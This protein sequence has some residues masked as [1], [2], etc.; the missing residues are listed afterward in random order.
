MRLKLVKA[1]AM[2]GFL[3]D[4]FVKRWYSNGLM[5]IPLL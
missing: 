5:D 4:L 3:K 1:P 2:I